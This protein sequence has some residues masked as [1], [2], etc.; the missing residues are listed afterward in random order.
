MYLQKNMN[1]IFFSII[2]PLYNKEKFISRSIQ[3]ILNQD[4]NNSYEIIVI[5]DGS[6]DSG[7]D[8]VKQIQKEHSCIIYYH[9]ENAGVSTARNMGIKLSKGNYIAFL[10]ADDYWAPYHLG[11]IAN[12]IKRFDNSCSIFSCGYKK[13]NTIEK[14][15]NEQ[16]NS[17]SFFVGI[18]PPYEKITLKKHLLH[19]SAITINKTLFKQ[20]EPFVSTLTH[21]EDLEFL[22]RI[23]LESQ[24][25]FDSRTSCIYLTDDLK[26]ATRKTPQFHD[27][28]FSHYIAQNKE[29]YYHI[30][31]NCFSRRLV[32]EYILW[33]LKEF[34]NDVQEFSFL[35]KSISFFELSINS[36]AKYV[37]YYLLFLAKHFNVFIHKQQ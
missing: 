6:T 20:T 27:N 31:D 25:A 18:L 19:I 30:K 10:D 22:L 3:S 15:W 17:K 33:G 13:T 9:Q 2:I 28:Y 8:I 21:G 23:G 34:L 14:R 32:N 35:R 26:S 29:K 4:Y 37:F 16:N 24:I 36:K 12:L 7:A 5:D 11:R 1:D